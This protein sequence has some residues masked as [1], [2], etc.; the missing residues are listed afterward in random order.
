M[1]GSSSGPLAGYLVADFSRVVAGPYAAMLLGD[2]GADVIKVERPGAGDD[3]RGFGPPFVGGD[4][5]DEDAETSAYYLAVNRNKL[6]VAWDL[7][8]PEGR[9]KAQGLA[10]RA[11]VLIENFKPGGA[12][13]LGLGYD[14]VAADNPGVVYCS[15]SGFGSKGQ[16][17][18][19]P[20]YDFLV[21]ALGGLMSITGDGTPRKVGVAV[22]DVLTALFASNAVLAG[23]V[24]RSS[25]GKGQRIEVDL[26]SSLLAGLINQASTYL[27]T[28]AIPRAM[29]NRHPSIAPYETFAAADRQ[30][31][32]AV[33]NDGQFA[34]LAALLGKAWMAVDRRFATNRAR[35]ENRLEMVG[36]LESSFA[37][38][39]AEEWAALLNAAGIPSGVVNDISEA[40][41]LAEELGL[42][43]VVRV[44]R[45][46]S[47][48]WR[49]SDADSRAQVRSPMRFGRTP[50]SYRVPAPGLGEHSSRVEA[51]LG[52]DEEPLGG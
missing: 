21:Q 4:S 20:G 22:V 15:I 27:T 44:T 16:G 12:T 34:T 14:D 51:E 46:L 2:L 28:G 43:P 13:R 50:V 40:F 7:A 17:A 18:D 26:L 24:E 52:L 49:G 1:N 10:R 41:S 11:D 42:S 9:R 30:F 35:V 29:G 33:G 45:Q 25:S 23:L 38:R 31:V 47:E 19:L 36:E 3:T 6:G 48:P 5:G 39:Q 8:T 37:H 32:V